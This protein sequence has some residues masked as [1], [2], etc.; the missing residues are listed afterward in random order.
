VGAEGG[1]AAGAIACA[2]AHDPD[3]CLL[4][5][6]MPG[7]GITAAHS[8]TRARPDTS[9]VML[10]VMLDDDHLFDALRAGARGY[11]VKGTDPDTLVTALRNT[12]DGEPAL[13][14]G[15]AMRIVEHLGASGSRRVHV[16]DVGAV[17]LSPREAEVLDLLRQ[18]LRTNEIARRLFISQVTVRTHI[19]SILKKL[20]A[21]DREEAIRMFDA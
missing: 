20:N 2:E 1:D 10:T 5:I 3:V 7:N 11:L 21:A 16:R 13:S 6:S 8:I 4:D 15:I 14:P 12:L 9:V 19:A 17:R 18:G